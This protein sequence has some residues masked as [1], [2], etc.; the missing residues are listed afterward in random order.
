MEQLSNVFNV[1]DG[2]HQNPVMVS[3][4]RELKQKAYP[5]VHALV[6]GFGQ[7]EKVCHL[8]RDRFDDKTKEVSR[9]G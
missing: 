6:A 9:L 5:E 8:F 2:E 3:L 4:L 7:D 1:K